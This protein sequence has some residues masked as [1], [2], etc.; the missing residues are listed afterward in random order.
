MIKS[1]LTYFV[2]F[3]YFISAWSHKHWSFTIIEVKYKFNQNLKSLK[4]SEA[5][6]NLHEC[7]YFSPWLTVSIF[8]TYLCSNNA[9]IL[10]LH[11][12]SKY[13]RLTDLWKLSIIKPGLQVRSLR[14][15]LC[16]TACV[17]FERS[18]NDIYI[19]IGT[20]F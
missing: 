20:W 13:S 8:S 11:S 19:Y 15:W 6:I 16:I 5:N 1:N 17:Q 4:Q 2:K 18:N 9:Y 12:L 3:M 10:K 7:T 14:F